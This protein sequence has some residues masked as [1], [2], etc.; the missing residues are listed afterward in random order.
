MSGAA[1]KV[2]LW[3]GTYSAGWEDLWFYE[4]RWTPEFSSSSGLS[5]HRSLSCWGWFWCL[6]SSGAN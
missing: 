3:L 5:E 2:R 6:D 1:G 4:I